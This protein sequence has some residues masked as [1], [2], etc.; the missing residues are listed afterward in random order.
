M[1]EHRITFQF[2][3]YVA[4]ASDLLWMIIL[5]A[6]ATPHQWVMVASLVSIGYLFHRIRRWPI[7]A[8]LVITVGL[9]LVG[10]GFLPGVLTVALIV[11]GVSWGFI[12]QIQPAQR[13]L[14]WALMITIAETVYRP[15]LW[16]VPWLV[17]AMG[18]LGLA[19]RSPREG[20]TTRLH[21]VIASLT[22]LVALLIAAAIAGLLWLIPWVFIVQNT[23]GR[24][25]ASL[26][27]LV[28][29]LHIHPNKHPTKSQPTHGHPPRALHVTNHTEPII[30]GI[31]LA[32]VVM[33]L[34]WVLWRLLRQADTDRDVMD[35]EESFIIR[36]HLTGLEPFSALLRSPPLTPVRQLVRRR[37]RKLRGKPQERRP[38]ET[39]RQWAMRVYGTEFQAITAY[40]DV[41]YGNTKDT[42]ALAKDV[43]KNW[44][45][46]N[47]IE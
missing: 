47:V 45:Q 22:G 34:I 43:E 18:L 1:R 24:L 38:G 14:M 46:Q 9:S 35:E 13:T 42:E 26:V 3:D 19:L 7:W 30:I 33:G 44:S 10:Y 12:S 8:S 16:W 20:I 15:T 32:L 40:E 28:P 27:S 25:A 6:L 23:V 41:R 17:L 37:L 11:L 39:L 4:W 5:V 21:G 29:L 31:L 36:E 2:A